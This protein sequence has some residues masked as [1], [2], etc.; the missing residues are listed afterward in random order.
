MPVRM[1]WVD[2]HKGMIMALAV[3]IVVSA[4]IGGV[5]TYVFGMWALVVTLPIA[6]LLGI[7]AAQIDSSGL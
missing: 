3:A 6:A 1:P 5:G 4:I 2:R 7:V